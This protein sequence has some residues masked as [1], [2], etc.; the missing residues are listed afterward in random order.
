MVFIVNGLS[1][2]YLFNDTFNMPIYDHVCGCSK[3]NHLLCG[4]LFPAQFIIPGRI[5]FWQG[6]FYGSI[7]LLITL[8]TVL[9]SIRYT[10][11]MRERLFRAFPFL[12]EKGK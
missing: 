1:L 10:G 2:T 11:L 4:F 5:D 8:M 12:L 6:W 9:A 3:I 7:N